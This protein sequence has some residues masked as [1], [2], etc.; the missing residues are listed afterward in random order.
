MKRASGF[1]L[2]ELMIVVVIVGVLMAIALPSYRDYT[3]RSHRADAHAALLDMA[4]RQER[5]VA[6]NNQY[7][8]EVA[9][10]NGLNLGTTTSPEGY[11]TLS[12]AACPTGNIQICYLLTATAIG[13]QTADTE[14]LN[15]TYDSTGTKGP[16]T[17]NCW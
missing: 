10:G 9:A 1:T 14:C 17:A 8:G 4:A 13:S 16:I 6:Q 5:F 15:I 7:T 3:L 12:A 2:V 11:Y